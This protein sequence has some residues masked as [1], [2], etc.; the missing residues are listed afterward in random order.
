MP[1]AKIEPL[2]MFDLGKEMIPWEQRREDGQA[3]RHKAS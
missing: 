3:L 1:I 2:P